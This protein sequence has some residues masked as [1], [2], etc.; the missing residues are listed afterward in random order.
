LCFAPTAWRRRRVALNRFARRG[1]ISGSLLALCADDGFYY[2]GVF[3]SVY[4]L[5]RAL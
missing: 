1:F 4:R 2:S 5:Q 3:L